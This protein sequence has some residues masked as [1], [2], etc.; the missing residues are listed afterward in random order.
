[1]KYITPLSKITLGQVES[2]Y[3]QGYQLEFYYNHIIPY[4]EFWK[5][6]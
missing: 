3:D 2:L 5:R 1:M 6:A 4:V